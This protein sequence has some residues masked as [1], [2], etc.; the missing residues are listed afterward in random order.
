MM[1]VLYG[2]LVNVVWR[3]VVG[4]DG[5]APEEG[6]VDDS[7]KRLCPR[8]RSTKGAINALSTLSQ[9]MEHL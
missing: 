1:E 4:E 7:N 3:E 8:E 5:S 9:T 6:Q 2:L